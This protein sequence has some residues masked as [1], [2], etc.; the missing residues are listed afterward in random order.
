MQ[1]HV[2]NY[3]KNLS[4]ILSLG[5]LVVLVFV[6]DCEET[7]DTLKPVDFVYLLAAFTAINRIKTIGFSAGILPGIYFYLTFKSTCKEFQKE[8]L[9]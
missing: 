4:D 7:I 1:H 8:I 9:I 2:K 6:I 5:M 3:E